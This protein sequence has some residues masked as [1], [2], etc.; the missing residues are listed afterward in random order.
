V[1]VV[2]DGKNV[3]RGRKSGESI[4]R[5][6]GVAWLEVRYRVVVNTPAQV[7]SVKGLG[8]EQADRPRAAFDGL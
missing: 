5:R 3:G 6:G 2:G 1:T 8:V 7:I 4:W